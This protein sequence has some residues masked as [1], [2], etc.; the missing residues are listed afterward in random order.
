MEYGELC[1]ENKNP[2]S[3]KIPT[4]FLSRARVLS[5]EV[6]SS[7]LVRVNVKLRSN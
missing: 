4:L 6:F 2:K 3:T 5:G 1:E 7:D